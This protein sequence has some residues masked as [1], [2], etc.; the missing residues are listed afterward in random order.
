[1]VDWYIGDVLTRSTLQEGSADFDGGPLPRFSGAVL[2]LDPPP[3][4]PFRGLEDWRAGRLE[5]WGTVADW[6]NWRIGDGPTRSTAGGVGGLVV[7]W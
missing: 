7:Q 3:K 1:M 4:S 2:V 5:D 6:R